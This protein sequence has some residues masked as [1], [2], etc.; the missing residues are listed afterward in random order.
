M[1]RGNW[2]NT[3]RFHQYP[4]HLIFYIN[5]DIEDFIF[6]FFFVCVQEFI[7]KLQEQQD[8]HELDQSEAARKC[9]GLVELLEAKEVQQALLE[10]EQKHAKE[11]LNMLQVKS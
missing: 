2:K 11:K 7:K 9:E 10:G 4:Y 5:Y 3:K 8:K 1:K 6:N